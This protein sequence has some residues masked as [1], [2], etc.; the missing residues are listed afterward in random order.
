MQLK[1]NWFKNKK[2]PQQ[3][4]GVE[5]GKNNTATHFDTELGSPVSSTFINEIQ[6]CWPDNVKH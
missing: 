1:L 6:L 2:V 4:S 5:N 3:W